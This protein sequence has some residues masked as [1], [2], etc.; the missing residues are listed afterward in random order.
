MFEQAVAIAKAQFEAL[1]ASQGVS[2]TWKVR[3]SAVPTTATNDIADAFGRMDPGASSFAA[4]TDT[5]AVFSAGTTIHVYKDAPSRSQAENA[6]QMVTGS[7][8][9]QCS[10]D[11]A[12]KVGDMLI[13]G[14]E[15]W[16]VEG[17]RLCAPP[18]YRELTLERREI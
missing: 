17:S 7:S 15:K 16:A 9:A 12:V 13:I 11:N 2:V 1:L 4:E 8:V 10:A 5:A 18:I 6:G 14:T 3:S